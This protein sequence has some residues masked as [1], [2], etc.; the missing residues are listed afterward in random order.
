MKGTP[1]DGTFKEVIKTCIGQE[2]RDVFHELRAQHICQ[3]TSVCFCLSVLELS[4]NMKA[5]LIATQT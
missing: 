1:T 5:V 4:L 3:G 2:L